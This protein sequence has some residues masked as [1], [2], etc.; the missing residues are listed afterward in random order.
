MINEINR[1]ND[2][3]QGIIVTTNSIKN[4]LNK[5]KPFL[6]KH[7][8]LTEKELYDLLGIN[9]DVD[10]YVN[11]NNLQ[12]E[13]QLLELAKLNQ[14]DKSNN[15]KINNLINL[16]KKMNIKLNQ[17]NTNIY[18][19]NIRNVFLEKKFS[20]KVIKTE[21][22]KKPITKFQTIED[23]IISVF[24]QIINLIN[25]NVCIND[26]SIIYSL[27][28]YESLLKFYSLLYKI[29]LIKDT[30]LSDNIEFQKFISNLNDDNILGE[31]SEDKY[32]LNL[33]NEIISLIN[34]Y[35]I[36]NKKQLIYFAKRKMIKKYQNGISITTL[37]NPN[38]KKYN[39]F[40]GMN[41]SV[42]PLLGKENF[43]LS[44]KELKEYKV[45]T[46]VENT[47]MFEMIS[48]FYLNLDH[49]YFSYTNRI[50]KQNYEYNKLYFDE[51]INESKSMYKNLI[52]FNGLMA[53]DL[54]KKY[55]YL[56]KYYGYNVNYL[57]YDSS[58]QKINQDINISQLS[59]TSMELYNN[60][61]FQFF[62]KKVL[63]IKEQSDPFRLY[64]GT[65]YH[66][67]Y[68][69]LD[70]NPSKEDILNVYQNEIKNLNINEDDLFY[71][72]QI[73]NNYLPYYHLVKDK[74]NEKFSDYKPLYKEQEFI[75]V[76]NSNRK[77][78]GKIDL[79]LEDNK[80]VVIVDYK[81]KAEPVTK[82]NLEKGDFQ[83]FI[84]MYLFENNESDYNIID[85]CRQSM[86]L[87]KDEKN[88]YN[89]KT[90][91]EK[92]EIDELKD[93]MKNKINEIDNLISENNFEIRESDKCKNCFFADICM[94]RFRE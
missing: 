50:F 16:N 85:T 81:T 93:Y 36:T 74:I 68:E 17:I 43:Y 37:K 78:V 70:D 1:L 48:N 2:Y 91:K 11:K 88:K 42:F 84:Y 87:K 77:L 31:L 75:H 59:A 30:K 69:V 63:K 76:L 25:Q 35:K 5:N 52:Q 23:E 20:A 7:R 39:F 62:I 9:Y 12:Y 53:N 28:E 47:Q 83:N 94:K 57:N 22:N 73:F 56:D 10:L 32:S 61:P 64:L 19:Y 4:Y 86:G 33:I 51:V 66:K 49:S 65:I 55:H 90:L 26:I 58:Y 71:L 13:Y 89:I 29:D 14:L 82:N 3:E 27:V 40:I 92:K 46:I 80:K 44:D 8:I 24:D 79:I 54:Y 60:C 45:N 6:F 72:E 21:L 34:K 38:L 18:L 41:D 15:D 67:L